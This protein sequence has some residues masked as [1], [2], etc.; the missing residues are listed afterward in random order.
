MIVGI[1]LGTT[2]SVISYWKEKEPH[3]ITINGNVLLPSVVSLTE[4][5]F[6]VG[7][8]AKNMA[9]LEPEKTVLSVKRKMGEDIEIQ[10]GDRKM[11]PEEV[12]A[13]ILK[14]LK[15]EAVKTL[16]L[17]ETELLRAVITVPAYFTET[18]REATKQAAESAGLQVERI[19]NEP[20]AAGLAF[21]MSAMDEAIYAV[22]D[23]GGGTFDV[24]VIESNEGMIEVL[25]STG[26]NLLGGDDLDDLLSEHIWE[27]FVNEN[28]IA[29]PTA[30]SKVKA[31]LKHIAE[32]IKIKLSKEEEY[33]I[34]E[35]F[36]FQQGDASYHIEQTITRATFENL[37]EAKV[38]E[39]IQHL[40]KAIKEAKI[41]E[42]ELDG[43]LLVGG[44]S[45]I[46]LV[47][48]KIEQRF[49]ISPMLISHPN[50]AIAHGATIQ[51]AIIED[52]NIDT[53]L[54]DI[55]PHS[56]GVGAL[57]DSAFSEQMFSPM[58]REP[59][60]VAAAIINKN[61]PIP[62]KRT[63]KFYAASPFQANFQMKLFQGE[64]S[65][66]N[67]NHEIGEMLLKVEDPP[68]HGEIE[69]T[70]SLDINGI[71]NVTAMETTTKQKVKAEFKS[72]RGYK[73]KKSTLEK[74]VLLS[75]D[76]SSQTLVTRGEN[77]LESLSNDEDKKELIELLEKYKA[78]HTSDD[79]QAV[80]VIESDLMDLLY[81]LE[82]EN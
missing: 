6:I 42:S 49:K 40:E 38:S 63:N 12:S 3:T 54:I 45:R 37:I 58:Q 35:S 30:N 41:Q 62:A 65:R 70:F 17:S 1:D 34:Q 39:T 13:V 78:A 4:E 14:K 73:A 66:F 23:F 11:R 44:S 10:V 52:I 71:L 18:Q 22:Y 82:N 5:G 46:P 56:L 27:N 32:K 48:Q 51:G 33:S 67:D 77:A 24:S 74:E 16:G 2:N 80:T 53:I 36:F 7:R 50:E 75:M 20:T 60:L 57:D 29:D 28:K 15:Q 19:I 21:G 72:S 79:Q 69:V 43:I 8:I 68:E 55:T 26:N 9:I 25:A 64:H 31:R 61:T 76:Q 47:A 59:D 81:Y